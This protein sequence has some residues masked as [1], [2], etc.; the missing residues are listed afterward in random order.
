MNAWAIFTGGVLLGL[1]LG[2][3]IGMLTLVLLLASK[4]EGVDG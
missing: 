4:D 2:G 3:S 1:M